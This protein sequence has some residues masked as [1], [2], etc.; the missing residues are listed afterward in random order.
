M[1]LS[2]LFADGIVNLQP[3]TVI[4]TNTYHTMHNTD[5]DQAISS[6]TNILELNCMG[7]TAVECFCTT[8]ALYFCS[9]QQ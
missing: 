6:L 7:K 5:K 9:S 3:C 8:S 1:F 2:A 4:I